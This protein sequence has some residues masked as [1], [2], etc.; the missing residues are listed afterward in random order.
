MSRGA[1]ASRVDFDDDHM[2]LRHSIT[3]ID[4]DHSE[5]WRRTTWAL[6]RSACYRRPRYVPVNQASQSDRLPHLL[7]AE[8]CLRTRCWSGDGL[9]VEQAPEVG[10]V[11][12]GGEQARGGQ[13]GAVARAAAV[14]V[15]PDDQLAHAAP[16][17]SEARASTWRA[18]SATSSRSIAVAMSASST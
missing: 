14:Q 16:G 8:T 15:G 13:G 3:S 10:V 6:G 18:P 9:A 4:T 11:D 2:R 7:T 17:G 1:V 5:G 12:T